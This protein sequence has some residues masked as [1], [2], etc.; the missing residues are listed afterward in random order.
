MICGECCLNIS[1][2]KRC[3]E[4]RCCQALLFCSDDCLQQHGQWVKIALTKLRAG[5]NLCKSNFRVHLCNVLEEFGLF[6]DLGRIVV[7]YSRPITMRPTFTEFLYPEFNVDP[8]FKIW[9]LSACCSMWQTHPK[10]G[11][12]VCNG[13]ILGW[14]LAVEL[15]VDEEMSHCRV[16][17][18]EFQDYKKTLELKWNDSEETTKI[19]VPDIYQITD[20]TEDWDE[21]TRDCVWTIYA[22]KFFFF[23][24]GVLYLFFLDELLKKRGTTAIVSACWQQRI[25]EPSKYRRYEM[26]FD[27]NYLVFCKSIMSYDKPFRKQVQIWQ[28]TRDS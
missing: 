19:F 14:Q 22:E 27:K 3:H 16:V 7:E 18:C 9:P 17:D 12:R 26:A 2:G 6:R 10:E 25:A 21:C 24:N 1:A 28:F 5:E 15:E 8:F 4:H 20:D 13:L 23:A 11:L